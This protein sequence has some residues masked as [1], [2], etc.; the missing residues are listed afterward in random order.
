MLCKSLIIS[1]LMDLCH[2]VSPVIK[3]WYVIMTIR[4]V[5]QLKYSSSWKDLFCVSL[6]LTALIL[7]R[8]LCCNVSAIIRNMKIVALI[9]LFLLRLWV[10]FDWCLDFCLACGLNTTSLLVWR[11]LTYFTWDGKNDDP[12]KCNKAKQTNKKSHRNTLAKSGKT[13]TLVSVIVIN[14]ILS[15]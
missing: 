10:L 12:L 2:S 4:N 11:T 6:Y 3:F 14:Q 9:S 5:W 8:S 15:M 1:P 13:V 7:L